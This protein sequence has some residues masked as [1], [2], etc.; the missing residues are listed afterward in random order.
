MSYLI[1]KWSR[2]RQ[3][4]LLDSF[5]FT[6]DCD[7]CSCKLVLFPRKSCTTQAAVISCRNPDGNET[8]DHQPSE[9]RYLEERHDNPQQ[10]LA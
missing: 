8:T 3:E 2:F 5:T 6:R 1:V 10:Y 4:M 7:S 9:S